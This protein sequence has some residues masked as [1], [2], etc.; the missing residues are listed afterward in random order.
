M[1]VRLRGLADRCIFCSF[2]ALKSRS[3]SL[4]PI[5]TQRLPG[6]VGTVRFRSVKTKPAL[7]AL[8]ESRQSGKKLTVTQLYNIVQAV[9]DKLK[10]PPLGSGQQE[11]YDD[12]N[13]S[14]DAYYYGLEIPARAVQKQFRNFSYSVLHGLQK[15]EF[16]DHGT[17]IVTTA[18]V[19]AAIH[20]SSRGLNEYLVRQ[21]LTY[22]HASTPDAVGH[23]AL[24]TNLKKAADLRFPQEWYPA[25][26]QFQ[27]TW[28][29][30]VGPTN[31][32]KTYHALQRLMESGSGCYA[33]PL[34]LL[35]HEV[36]ERMNAQGYPCN[37]VTGDDRQTPS[38]TAQLTS[39]TV[40]MVDVTRAMEVCVLDEIQMIGDPDRGWAWT[41]ALMGVKAKEVHLCGEE[42]TIELIQNLAG[43]MG[44][45]L[46][47]RHYKRLGPLEVMPKSLGGNLRKLERGDCVVTFSRT[48]IF[49]LQREIQKVTGKKCAVIYGS[50]PPET[51]AIQAKL[52][53]NPDN[54]YEILVA[55]DAVGMGLN[56]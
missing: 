38:D 16:S 2:S 45:K 55:S 20:E 17:F 35:A 11:F 53:N 9:L 49:A 42:R 34:R 37:L 23:E 19:E 36:F 50:L 12:T 56:L 27:R 33:G 22:I 39:C 14:P 44:D 6:T 10:P 43:T 29:L 51:R 30:H 25:T 4:P 5:F 28:Y 40:E 52:F 26:R 7:R 8:T 31:S 21:F 47:I 54:D 13:T 46:V 15:S 3:R 24:S 32:G 48:S 1:A 41:Q 18:D